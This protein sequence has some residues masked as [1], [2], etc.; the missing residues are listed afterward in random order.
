MPRLDGHDADTPAAPAKLLRRSRPQDQ[1]GL[2]IAA[3]PGM[4][5][6]SCSMPRTKEE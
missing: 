1:A 3:Y 6:G 4:R 2:E 5:T